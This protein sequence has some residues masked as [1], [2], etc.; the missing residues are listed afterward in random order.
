MLILCNKFLRI[1]V[2]VLLSFFL[3]LPSKVWAEPVVFFAEDLG[4]TSPNTIPNSLAAQAA[5][6][7]QLP[8]FGIEDFE[9]FSVVTDLN[10]DPTAR[11]SFSGTSISGAAIG[12]PAGAVVIDQVN[13]VWVGPGRFPI[14][15]TNFVRTLGGCSRASGP[16][17]GGTH[18]EYCP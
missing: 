9:S 14:S 8:K 4:P 2:Q 5:F 18:R 11:L 17:C 12:D 15:G 6:L 7:S 1:S 10:T 16:V 3:I 13:D